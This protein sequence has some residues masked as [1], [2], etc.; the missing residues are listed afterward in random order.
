VVSSAFCRTIDKSYSLCNY[1]EHLSKRSGDSIRAQNKF[2]DP[3]SFRNYAKLIFS[4]NKIPESDDDSSYA[5]YRRWLII[6]FD[7][8]GTF[9]SCNKSEHTTEYCNAYRAG[10]VESDVNDNPDENIT[11]SKVPCEGGSPGSEYCAGYQQG[12]ADED[13]AMFSPHYP[14]SSFSFCFRHG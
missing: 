1:K 10:A 6:E 5:Y 13:Q 2:K 4:A 9:V 11:P 7:T 8:G 3:F 12:Y 14:S